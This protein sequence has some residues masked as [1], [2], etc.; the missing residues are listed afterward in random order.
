MPDR[1]CT[2]IIVSFSNCGRRRWR[3]IGELRQRDQLIAGRGLLQLTQCDVG[4]DYL[5]FRLGG[6]Q[7]IERETITR[8]ALRKRL[9]YPGNRKVV[10]ADTR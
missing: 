10:F 5:V 8:T 9:L 7:M 3:D 1:A 2:A 4:Q 6:R